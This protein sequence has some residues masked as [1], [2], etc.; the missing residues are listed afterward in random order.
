MIELHDEVSVFWQRIQEV[1][2]KITERI[3]NQDETESH[4]LIL[5]NGMWLTV[6]DLNS[7]NIFLLQMLMHEALKQKA[8]VI[9]VAKDTTSTDFTRSALPLALK[10]SG[11]ERSELPGLKNDKL[12]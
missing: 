11:K 1:T 2:L 4:P 3:F 5:P 9:G 7:L 8:L 6:T 10:S 12:C